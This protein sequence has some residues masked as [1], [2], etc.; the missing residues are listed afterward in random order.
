MSKLRP[1]S[2][3]ALRDPCATP[4]SPDPAETSLVEANQRL[5][6]IQFANEVATWTWDIL[7]NKVV[8]DE[9]LT[10]L[11]GVSDEDASGGPIE[12]YILAIHP[13]DR[14]AVNTAI[15]KALEG[16]NDR[17]QTNYRIVEKDGGT[18]WVSARGTVE[19]GP[20]VNLAIF[21]E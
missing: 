12:K 14:S 21:Q 5:K 19:R 17:Y 16:P 13:D 15:T 11:F 2:N 18:S 4:G 7:N 8:A 6:S 10:R 20:T 3:G 1:K 9:N